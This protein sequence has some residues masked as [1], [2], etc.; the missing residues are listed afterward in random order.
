[1]RS[2]WFKYLLNGLVGLPAMFRHIRKVNRLKQIADSNPQ[3]PEQWAAQRE[4]LKELNRMQRDG[5]M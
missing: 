5:E 2:Q 1:M 3:T 4:A